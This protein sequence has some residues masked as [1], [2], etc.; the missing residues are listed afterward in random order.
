MEIL[1]KNSRQQPSPQPSNPT[2]TRDTLSQMWN[3]NKQNTW[4]VSPQR[5]HQTNKTYRKKSWSL[6]ICYKPQSCSPALQFCDFCNYN[7]GAVWSQKAH[8]WYWCTYLNLL[9]IL[10][11]TKVDIWVIFIHKRTLGLC[12]IRRSKTCYLSLNLG[13]G[14]HFQTVS[15][16]SHL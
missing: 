16:E 5:S 14:A 15:R 2:Q 3:K 11:V 12:L 4:Q 6:K 1:D 7:T 10:H 9:H 8:V 13:I